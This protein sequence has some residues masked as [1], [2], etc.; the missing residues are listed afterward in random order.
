MARLDPV[1]HEGLLIALLISMVMLAPFSI[2]AYLPVLPEISAD[3]GAPDA[4]VQFSVGG[5]LLGTALGPLA[6]GPLSDRFGRRALLLSGLIGFSVFAVACA[7]AQSG[8]ALVAF[9]LAQAVCGS[10]ALVAGQALLADL[11]G[12]DRLAQRNSFLMIFIS[13]A[14]M[15]APVYGA[16]LAAMAGWRMI[17]WSLALFSAV[18]VGVAIAKLPETLARDRRDNLD[19]AALIRGYL[20]VARHPVAALYMLAAFGMSGAFFAYLAGSPFL[21]IE[22]FGLTAGQFALIFSVG[23]A[24]AAAGNGANIALVARIGFRRTLLGQGIV[25]LALGALIFAGCFGLLGRWA[26]YAGGLALMPVQHWITANTL[27]GVMAQF[28]RRRGLASA[29]ALALRFSGG[30]LAVAAMGAGRRAGTIWPHS[31]CVPRSWRDLCTVGRA[32]GR[33]GMTKTTIRELGGADQEIWLSMYRQ[34]WPDHRDEDLAAEID[35]IRKSSKR[36]AFVAEVGGTPA[37]FAEYALRDYAN[38]C[39][40]QPVPFL[41][42]IWVAESFRGQGIARALMEFLSDRARRAGFTEFGSDVELSN[43]ASQLMHERMGF[44]QTEKVIYYR[45]VLK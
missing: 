17:F 39:H 37:G 27:S 9:R 36:S 13:L 12:G 20:D 15:I 42:G 33:S 3:L 44:E 18:I 31:L 38:G 30:T 34:L 8:W 41:E 26:I 21:Y 16:W 22:V 29:V 5:F 11:Y 7:L 6:A 40:S 25:A 45:K 32:A 14:P 23:A 4:V 19:P 1:R 35:R 43:Y 24:L 10:A 28:D 2:D